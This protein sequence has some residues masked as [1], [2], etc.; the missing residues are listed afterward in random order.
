MNARRNHRGRRPL[1]TALSLIAI[2]LAPFAAAAQS[3]EVYSGLNPHREQL[4]GVADVQFC[5]GG[6]Q[7]AAGTQTV[8]PGAAGFNNIV[9]E[10]K[11]AANP[12]AGPWRFSYDSGRS[13]D[14][15]G[16]VEYTDGSGFAVVG[17]LE[18]TFCPACGLAVVE[19]LRAAGVP[20]P[21]V[22]AYVL[23]LASMA[24]QAAC[25]VKSRSIKPKKLLASGWQFATIAA[26]SAGSNCDAPPSACTATGR[27][28]P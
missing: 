27:A 25:W 3:W 16:I 2:A 4:Q 28:R 20:T 9:V 24:A 23:C 17:T 8:P 14:G 12:V 26:R 1:P 19:R 10:R 13:E 18:D 15:R 21:A 6:G 22:V 5:P 11:N 7:V